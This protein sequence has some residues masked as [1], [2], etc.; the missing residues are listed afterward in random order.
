MRYHGD[1]DWPG[2]AIANEVIT[3]LGAS[4]WQFSAKDYQAA[5]QAEVT[6]TRP[7]VGKA[8]TARWDGALSAAMQTSGRAID[9]EAL[10]ASLLI[11]LDSRA[12]HEHIRQGTFNRVPDK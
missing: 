5:P 6:A 1:F 2:I 8:V 9:E 7:L 3:M 11:D 12:G 10:A 4:A